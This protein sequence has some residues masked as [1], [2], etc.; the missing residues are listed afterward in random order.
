MNIRRNVLIGFVEERKNMERKE[1]SEEKK[2]RYV[3]EK[4]MSLKQIKN[5]G[6][7]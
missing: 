3:K 5:D 1:K 2:K 4:G 7:K 6:K